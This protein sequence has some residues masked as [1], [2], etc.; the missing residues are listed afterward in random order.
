[1][2]GK[3]KSNKRITT[4]NY[5]SGE[6]PRNRPLYNKRFAFSNLEPPKDFLNQRFQDI[7]NSDFLY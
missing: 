1:M 6:L 4:T 7:P 2:R 3:S 5:Q